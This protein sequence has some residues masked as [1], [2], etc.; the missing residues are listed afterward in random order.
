VARRASWPVNPVHRVIRLNG[1][2]DCCQRSRLIPSIRRP[3]PP[4][5]KGGE[6]PR[7]E[8]GRSRFFLAELLEHPGCRGLLH[9]R[10]AG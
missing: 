4:P 9:A 1:S 2:L 6:I 3:K 7:I 5:Q 8:I 10:E